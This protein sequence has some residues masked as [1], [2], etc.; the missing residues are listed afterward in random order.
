MPKQASQS[1]STDLNLRNDALGSPLHNPKV[2]EAFERAD[3]WDDFGNDVRR[4]VD[5]LMCSVSLASELN[6]DRLSDVLDTARSAEEWS[7]PYAQCPTCNQ[8]GCKTCRMKGWLTKPVYEV[9]AQH[10]EQG[11]E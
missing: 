10:L 2:S 1:K 3:A 7:R 4:A 5:D 6:G 11:D 9:V 8:A